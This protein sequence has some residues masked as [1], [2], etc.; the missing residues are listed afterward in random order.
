MHSFPNAVPEGTRVPQWALID[1]TVRC[2]LSFMR[3]ANR[4]PQ[5]ENVWDSVKSMNI[6]GR[7]L[8]LSV[9]PWPLHTYAV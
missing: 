6:G 3:P 2:C 9:F 5:V 1:V 7:N 8:L 4:T